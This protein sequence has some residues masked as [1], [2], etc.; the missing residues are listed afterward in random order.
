MKVVRLTRFV[1]P[2]VAAF[3]L[4]FCFFSLANAASTV[5][6]VNVTGVVACDTSQTLCA[7]WNKA[8]GFINPSISV[9]YNAQIENSSGQIIP[10]GGT[11]PSGT[12]IT[13]QCIPHANDDISWFTTGGAWDSPYGTWNTPGAIS[14]TDQYYA[15]TD[16][17]G[18]EGKIYANLSLQYPTQNVTGTSQLTGCTTLSDGCSMTC[19][20]TN[21]G[22]A[23]VTVPVA[24]SYSSTNGSFYGAAQWINGAGKAVAACETPD[25][26]LPIKQVAARYLTNPGASGNIWNG[27]LAAPPGTTIVTIPSARIPYPL[28]ITPSGSTNTPTTNTTGTGSGS[29]TSGDCPGT[30]HH[31]RSQSAQNVTSCSVS[32]TN[33][34]GTG[35]NTTG[36]WGCTGLQCLENST[37][38]TPI[39][40]QTIYTLLCTALDNSTTSKQAIV[41]VIS[42][43]QEK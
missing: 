40:S 6:N 42:V 8:W 20:A 30:L 41:N 38:S 17:E 43:F 39:A 16:T 32:G 23:P 19:T 13:L 18:Q 21:T 22:T 36:V 9:E 27:F 35:G 37:T 5:V 10:P 2:L 28:T 26:P 29:C 4:V 1:A 3:M 15:T 7:S 12:Q 24:F 14:C 11:V 33:G 25:F 34:D 31:R